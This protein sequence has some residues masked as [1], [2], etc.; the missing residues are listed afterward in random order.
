MQQSISYV[1]VDVS[2]H[3]LDIAVPG[4]ALGTRQVW[5][6]K[7]DAGGIKAP[8]RRMAVLDRPQFVCEATGG[9]TRALVQGMAAVTTPMSRINPRQVRDL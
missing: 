9:G 2:K 3:H 8:A 6:T 5:R 7:N 1:G 4:H